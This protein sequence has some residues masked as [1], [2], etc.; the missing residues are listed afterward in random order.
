MSSGGS[1][2]T[3][4]S[5]SATPTKKMSKFVVGSDG[6]GSDDNKEKENEEKSLMKREARKRPVSAERKRSMKSA[7]SSNKNGSTG[8]DAL[9]FEMDL[10]ETS[11][12]N[13]STTNS[14][15]SPKRTVFKL[16]LVKAR[17][18]DSDSDCVT[19]M[20]AG[21]ARDK[22][23]RGRRGREKVLDGSRSGRISG[24]KRR[25]SGLGNEAV[26]IWIYAYTLTVR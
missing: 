17:G 12:T 7:D 26:R 24:M 8:D 23:M 10:G 4:L 22:E 16:P 3:T 9:V 5:V 21:G 18:E 19:P 14:N 25:R 11:T 2:P 1:A 20:P 13:A 6:S 15:G